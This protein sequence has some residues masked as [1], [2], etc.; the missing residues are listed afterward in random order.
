M[1]SFFTFPFMLFTEC[2]GTSRIFLSDGDFADC[3]A[4]CNLSSFFVPLHQFSYADF[5]KLES[6]HSQPCGL[7]LARFVRC[8]LLLTLFAVTNWITRA[9]NE[10]CWGRIILQLL[11]CCTIAIWTWFGSG[12]SQFWGYT[13]PEGLLQGLTLEIQKL[14]FP[15]VNRLRYENCSQVAKTYNILPALL[16]WIKLMREV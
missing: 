2:S 7:F 10:H 12:L 4:C 5:H 3:K 11:F 14:F 6:H 16:T 8:P 15:L 13:L 1:N 9:R